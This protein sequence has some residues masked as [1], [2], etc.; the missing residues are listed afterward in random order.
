[1]RPKTPLAA[2]SLLVGLAWLGAPAAA[3]DPVRAFA[4]LA[5]GDSSAAVDA[6]LRQDVIAGRFDRD[7]YGCPIYARVGDLK[8]E[9]SPEFHEDRL[10]RLALRHT[11]KVRGSGAEPDLEPAWQDLR[12]MITARHGAAQVVRER[13]PRLPGH[14]DATERVQVVTHRWSPPGRRIQLGVVARTEYETTR[15]SLWTRIQNG[16]AFTDR[17]DQVKTVHYEVEVVVTDTEAEARIARASQARPRA[18]RSARIRQGADL[19]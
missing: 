6:K 9:L 11:S 19:F 14:G 4:D 7:C 13:A 16:W 18:A 8:L 5:F 1:M 3:A 12:D 17:P 10:W 2:A 15:E